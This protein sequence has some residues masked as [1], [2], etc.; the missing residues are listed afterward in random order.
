MSTTTAPA[1]RD[2]ATLLAV[3]VCA[4]VIA[5]LVYLTSL[6]RQASLNR[7]QVGF[8]GLHV[9]LK[10]QDIETLTFQGGGAL[11][12]EDIGLRVLPLFDTDLDRFSEEPETEA[13]MM[14]QT[15]EYDISNEVLHEKID[16]VPSLVILPKW[17]RAVRIKGVAHPAFL[18]PEADIQRVQSQIYGLGG[19]ISRPRDGYVEE[20]YSFAGRTYNAGLYQPQ[21]VSN[22]DCTPILGDKNAMLLGKCLGDEGDFWLLSDPDLLNAHGLALGENASLGR[23]ILA[24]LAADNRV[25]I[26]LTSSI[27][28]SERPQQN[29]RSWSDLARFGTYPFSIVWAGFAIVSA[30]FLW[31]AWVRYGPVVRLFEDR[32][33]ASK[34]GSIDATARLLRLSGHDRKLLQSHIAARCRMLASD[35][36]GP[37]RAT[38]TEPVQELV[39][40]IRQR[41]PEL[42][43]DLAG[44][45]E[46]IQHGQHIKS[47][48]EL[49]HLLDRFET[50]Y[51]RTLHEFG[52]SAEPRP[53]HPR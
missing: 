4:I 53:I 36:L 8:A 26:D 27:F 51:E 7:S 1:H 3:A 5:G 29:A 16:L 45:A 18:I 32:P 31:H 17:R 35:L 38:G 9:W 39:R 49:L 37:H 48:A 52:R 24:D 12:V 13:E 6:E 25:I 19:S 14:K 10:D 50:L 28:I 15:T 47:H 33:R 43:H 21:F 34:T 20:T 44:T 41:S 23:D 46:E 42:A 22:S 40:I 2:P 11:R 30:L